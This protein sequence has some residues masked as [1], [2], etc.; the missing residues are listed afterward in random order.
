MRIAVFSDTHNKHDEVEVPDADILLFAGDLS[1]CRRPHDLSA[2]NGFLKKLPH[3]HKIVI[4]G[5]HDHLFAENS[6]RARSLL[7]EAIYLED[8]MVV[9]NGVSIYGSPWQPLFNAQACDA[10]ALPRGKPLQEKWQMIP[11]GTDILV[12]HSPPAGILDQDGPVAHGCGDLA[13]AVR[14]I[15]P[16][17]H[18]F[19]HIHSNHGCLSH[20]QTMYINCN[21]QAGRKKIRPALVFTFSGNAGD[22]IGSA[23]GAT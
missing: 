14:N 20:E 22:L 6:L 10:F 9:I 7:S 8:E 11:E 13:M 3:R 19:G 23:Q 5:N 15:R 4:A 12:T 21:V 16:K 1:D 17:Y 2:F 18:V